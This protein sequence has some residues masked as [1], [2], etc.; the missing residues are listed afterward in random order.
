M[1]PSV[2]LRLELNRTVEL[3]STYS[4]TDN[5]NKNANKSNIYVY[6]HTHIHTHIYL[7]SVSWEMSMWFDEQNTD[8]NSS[9]I[10]LVFGRNYSQGHLC[11]LLFKLGWLL[12]ESNPDS[13]VRKKKIWTLRFSFKLR[14]SF[15]HSNIRHNLLYSV[16]LIAMIGLE[17]QKS[18]R[19]IL[20]ILKGYFFLSST[21][22]RQWNYIMYLQIIQL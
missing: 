10:V 4:S 15:L 20:H 6:T 8:V 14:N 5:A 11:W 13:F 18:Q 21:L 7:N 16:R 12:F 17:I 2:S 9:T 19:K 1:E 22:L 3:N